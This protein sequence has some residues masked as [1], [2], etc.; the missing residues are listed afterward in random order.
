MRVGGQHHA[1]TAL[2]PG[3]T[4]GSHCMERLMG[5]K[6]GLSD[7]G[8]S[9]R[10]RDS[11]HGPVFSYLHLVPRLRKSG[12][13]LL[14]PPYISLCRGQG[15]LFLFTFTIT[16]STAAVLSSGPLCGQSGLVWTAWPWRWRHYCPSKFGGLN[17]KV[18]NSIPYRKNR[19]ERNVSVS[20]MAL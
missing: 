20:C 9:R 8:K 12:A 1:S 19:E 14:F 18:Q 6:A 11:V 17:L 3:N 4:P 16:L 10:H 15:Q 2:P 5:S 13:L 7:W